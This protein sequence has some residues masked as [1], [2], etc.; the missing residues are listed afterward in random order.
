MNA[1]KQRNQLTN[2]TWKEVS[3]VLLTFMDDLSRVY[4]YPGTLAAHER[5]WE[6]ALTEKRNDKPMAVASSLA[7][8]RLARVGVSFRWTRT[9]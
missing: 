6:D 7:T 2:E 9:S 5:G 1:T 3:N 8:F 4:I